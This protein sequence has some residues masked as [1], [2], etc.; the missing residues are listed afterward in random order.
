[1]LWKPTLTLDVLQKGG[2]KTIHESL[3][4]EFTRIGPDFLEAQMPVDERTQQLAGLLHGGASAVLCESLGSVAS[5]CVHHS[6]PITQVLGV[7]LHVQ[8]LN[9]A[10]SGKVVGRVSAVKLGKTLHR[11]QISVF[12]WSPEAPENQ[13]ALI[14]SGQLTVFVSYS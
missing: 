8:H 14:C 2:K 7:D 13:G 6:P 1:M 3:G 10:R 12:L 5:L 11:W 9:P 4:I